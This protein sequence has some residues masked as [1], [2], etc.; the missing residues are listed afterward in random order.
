MPAPPAADLRANLPPALTVLNVGCGS[1]SRQRLHRHFHDPKWREI[2]LDLDPA[3][4][5]DIVCSITD[6]HPVASA[7]VD[8]VWSSH[9]LEH[10]YRHEVPVALA[11]FLRV[12]KPRGL[13]LL[14]V[15]DLQQVAQLVAT[16]C[17]E[18]QA[19]MSPAGPITPLDMI[20]G[21]TSSLARGYPFMAH[22]TGFTARSLHNLLVNA[23][24]AEATVRPGDAFDLWAHA[25]KPGRSIA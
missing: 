10:V 21:H 20:F 14:T 15:P 9:N 13:L 7:S 18:D 17:L 5:P 3:V 12:L 4:Q 25:Y 23:G 16:D 6:M 8:A 2:R 24:F 11:E 22:K 19:Y 1:P